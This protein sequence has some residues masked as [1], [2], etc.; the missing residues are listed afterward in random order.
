MS[1]MILTQNDAQINT[2]PRFY[3]YGEDQN[4]LDQSQLSSSI[5]CESANDVGG[6][7]ELLLE[8]DYQYILPDIRFC[9]I[10]AK[11][12]VSWKNRKTGET[13]TS[14]TPIPIPIQIVNRT[15]GAIGAITC[16][17]PA[18]N[19]RK[20]IITNIRIY[21]IA[22]G[23][24]QPWGILSS[25][26]LGFISTE[27][28]FPQYFIEKCLQLNN[29]YFQRHVCTM[30]WEQECR[31]L[32]S[33]STPA[34][35]AQFLCEVARAG[36]LVSA[37]APIDSDTIEISGDTIKK[38]LKEQGKV[39]SRTRLMYALHEVNFIE[40][41]TWHGVQRKRNNT[42][43]MVYTI[44]KNSAEY[45]A[46]MKIE[47]LQEQGMNFKFSASKIWNDDNL[48]NTNDS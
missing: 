3:V 46:G 45:F 17:I 15:N 30:T 8:D 5:I 14:I 34:L 32:N 2:I 40:N 39:C 44:N 1:D 12:E 27:R 24:G 33:W 37:C 19:N 16:L 36:E 26:K 21:R 18:I 38:F 4:H 48:P 7:N 28:M 43:K 31:D 23:T 47:E 10:H 35:V 20:S 25:E 6:I 29:D 11:N 13:I 9:S 41:E 42:K 22:K